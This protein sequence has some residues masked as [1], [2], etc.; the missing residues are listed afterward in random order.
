[1]GQAAVQRP[2]TG[3]ARLR[4]RPALGRYTLRGVAL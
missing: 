2:T 4:A 1:M 3:R